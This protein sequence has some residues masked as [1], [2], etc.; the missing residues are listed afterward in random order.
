[1]GRRLKHI[2]PPPKPPYLRKV[3]RKKLIT[4]GR[5]GPP[6]T[7]ARQTPAARR[8]EPGQTRK[9]SPPHRKERMQCEQKSAAITS[10]QRR[11]KVTKVGPLKKKVRARGL[12]GQ[13]RREE[14]RPK[15]LSVIPGVYS[16]RDLSD[17]PKNS[18]WSLQVT[19]SASNDGQRKSD[20]GALF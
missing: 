15:A 6:L 19:R 1:M 20:R 7:C 13:Q 3:Q 4:Q 2:S 5:R 9:I 17:V 8:I 16:G 14:P 10:S 12:N 18:S 11:S